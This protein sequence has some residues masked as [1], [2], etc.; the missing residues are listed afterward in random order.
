MF[1]F[2]IKLIARYANTASGV[3]HD[4]AHPWANWNPR[5]TNNQNR[6]QQHRT[7]ATEGQ[8]GTPQRTTINQKAEHDTNI[9][10]TNS[11]R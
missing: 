3:G 8:S 5:F 1:L 11:F 10:T 2:H 6:E 4:A 9:T 7:I